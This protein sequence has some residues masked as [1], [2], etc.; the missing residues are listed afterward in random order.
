[1]PQINLLKQTSEER[2]WQE[3]IPSIA[4]KVLAA[5]V[6]ALVAYYAWI[7]VRTNRA[8][9]EAL[10]LSNEIAASQADVAN[11]KRSDELFV[12]QN[13]LKELSTIINNHLYW[14]NL[15]PELARVTLN[16]A[17]F[18]RLNAQ[19]SGLLTM[20]VSVP[21]YQELDK[22]IQVFDL[23]EFNKNF[24]DL[25]IT[26]MTEVQTAAGMNVTCGIELKF[27]PNLLKLGK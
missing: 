14:A 3:I 23:P 5:A 11:I 9:A 12:R 25:R 26:S 1:M 15:L 7:Y 19:S 21:N 6:I 2:R 17:S 8:N 18:T 20:Q 24:S 22:F 13:Q 16:S 4:V 10:S 27:N